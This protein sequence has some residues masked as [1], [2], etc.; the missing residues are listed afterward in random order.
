[1]ETTT[2]EIRQKLFDD[3]KSQ[4]IGLAKSMRASGADDK[5]I[6]KAIRF[7]ID[8][9]VKSFYEEKKGLQSIG[10][11][12]REWILT[13]YMNPDSKAEMIFYEALTGA[14]IKFQFQYKSGPYRADYLIGDTLVVELDGPQHRQKARA[15]LDMN[16]DAYMVK[17]GYHI[18]RLPLEI[19]AMDCNAVIEGIKELING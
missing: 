9:K 10:E 16:R 12:I 11:T 6:Q 14:G 18:L 2:K 7:Q 5:Q 8:N 19:I 3:N 17:K 15:E 13:E 1:M 4:F